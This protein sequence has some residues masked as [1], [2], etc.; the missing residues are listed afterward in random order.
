M[1]VETVRQVAQICAFVGVVAGFWHIL[2]IAGV[3]ILV[4]G[5]VGGAVLS[6]SYWRLRQDQMPLPQESE[7]SGSTG[8]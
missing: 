5:L 2:W 7:A 4:S 8:P 1:V 3:G 6:V